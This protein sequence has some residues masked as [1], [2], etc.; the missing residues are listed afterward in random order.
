M[1][2][3]VR[4]HPLTGDRRASSRSMALTLALY[5]SADRASGRSVP[6]V[7]IPPQP[8][9]SSAGAEQQATAEEKKD[10]APTSPKG[11][12][13]YH[14]P[15][16]ANN[17][18]NSNQPSA[19]VV[20]PR[21]S[22]NMALMPLVNVEAQQQ[23]QQQQQKARGQSLYVKSPPRATPPA[24]LPVVSVPTTSASSAS[25][26]PQ[27]TGATSPPSDAQSA[28]MSIPAGQ[29][30]NVGQWM[31]FLAECGLPQ[32]SRLAIWLVNEGVELEE[33]RYESL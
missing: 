16:E 11:L 12:L 13:I 15:E 29:E 33:S 9:K 23:Q 1:H 31:A 18:S 30:S 17:S 14:S 27:R 3:S 5:S 25:S 8:P 20:S 6:P 10:D 26:P 32:A 7:A 2:S 22:V 4:L 24:T 19:A 28:S 21:R